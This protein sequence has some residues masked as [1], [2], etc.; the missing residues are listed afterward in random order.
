MAVAITVVALLVTGRDD[1]VATTSASSSQAS[2]A[3]TTTTI[4]NTQAEVTARLREIIQV[5]EKAFAERDAS[6]FDDVYTSDCS[7][8]EAG[9]SAIA[10]LEREKVLW[11]NR[12]TSIEVQSAKQVNRRLWEV[13]GIF[14]S[15][16]FRIETEQGQLVREAPAERIRYRFLL[17]RSSDS[18]LWRLGS[19]TALE[20]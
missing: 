16:A 11:R 17:V 8:L 1:K 9:R 12:S 6:L 20:G 4:P 5:R 14:V 15:D 18:E 10:A 19:A 13:V 3:A 2:L 7:C